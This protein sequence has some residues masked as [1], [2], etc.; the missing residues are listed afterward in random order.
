MSALRSDGWSVRPSFSPHGP[1]EPVTLLMDEA[2]MTQL[3]G[4]PAVAWQIP[5]SEVGHLRLLRRG[6]RLVIVAVISQVMYQWRRSEP[7]SRDQIDE[8]TTVL[9]AHGARQTPRSRRSRALAVVAVVT[10]ASLL[11]YVGGLLASSSTPSVLR[12][13][14]TVNLSAR[15]VAGTWASTNLSSASALSFVMPA[16]GQVLTNNPST[17]L[18]AQDSSFTLSANHFQR[19]LGVSNVDDRVYGLAGQVATY[20]VSSPIFST[21]TVGGV[22]VQSTAQYYD[23]TL[24]VAADVAEMSRASF[25]R[26]FDESNADMLVGRAMS[27]TPNFTNGENLSVPTFAK[28]W[29]RGGAVSVSLPVIGIAH[30]SLVVIVEASGHYEVTLAALVANLSQARS[31]ID[32]LANSLLVHITSSSA[33]SA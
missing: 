15:D 6:R 24:S 31:T 27:S 19:C 20:Q 29:V 14:K 17:T 4:S 26:C 11:G 21:S 30:A 28:G 16:P 9:N 22:Q 25:G 12:Q 1:T 33:V 5:W 3:A 7:L 10:A 23:S 13:L 18:P 2:G 8:L 32:N